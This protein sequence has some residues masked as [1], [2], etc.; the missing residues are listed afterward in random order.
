MP[1]AHS[2]MIGR[3]ADDDD[4]WLD[5]VSDPEEGETTEFRLVVRDP[6]YASGFRTTSPFTTDQ[7]PSDVAKQLG[8]TGDVVRVIYGMS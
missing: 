1:G 3:D 2:I 8:L 6:G 5:D 4:D 7:S